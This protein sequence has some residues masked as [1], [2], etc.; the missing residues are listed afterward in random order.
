MKKKS[1]R[2]TKEDRNRGASVEVASKEMDCT[3]C[4]TASDLKRLS[5]ITEYSEPGSSVSGDRDDRGIEDKSV[6]SAQ[7]ARIIGAE[8]TAGIS[9]SDSI[10][11]VGLDG[12]VLPDESEDEK[13][14]RYF[15]VDDSP[16]AKFSRSVKWAYKK[17]SKRITSTITSWRGK[18][19]HFLLI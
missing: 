2:T 14:V 19:D 18:T 9:R 17:V 16:M 13:N 5:T 1:G 6:K 7:S 12:L 8:R 3:V 4:V 15:L 10:V 11:D